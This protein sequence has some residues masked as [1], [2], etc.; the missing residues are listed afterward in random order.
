MSNST[1]LTIGDTYPIY[2]K[3]TDFTP[4]GLWS[5]RAFLTDSAATTIECE[6]TSTTYNNET[7]E[8]ASIFMPDDTALL[9]SGIASLTI[10]FYKDFVP[11]LAVKDTRTALAGHVITVK[12]A[13]EMD[14]NMEYFTSMLVQVRACIKAR[15]TGGVEE[16]TVADYSMRYLD[17]DKLTKLEKYYQN[18]VDAYN[19]VEPTKPLQVT[20]YN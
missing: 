13:T 8:W 2:Y 16:Y 10:R 3:T 17:L 7:C 12:S 1:T 15:L 5:L 11:A 4:D 19:N 20:F 6:A 14:A 18:K 9:I